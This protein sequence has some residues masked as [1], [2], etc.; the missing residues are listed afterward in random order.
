M[1]EFFFQ[2]DSLVV[3]EV[4]LYIY[5]KIKHN[6]KSN[7]ICICIDDSFLY[8]NSGTNTDEIKI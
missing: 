7:T 1:K 8:I 3:E 6:E 2:A 4:S 5:K